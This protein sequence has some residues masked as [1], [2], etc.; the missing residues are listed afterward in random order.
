MGTRAER[1][2]AGKRVDNLAMGQGMGCAALGGI[3]TFSS[4]LDGVDR[5]KI[6]QNANDY[7]IQYM[8]PK[9]KLNEGDE[10]AIYARKYQQKSL[11]PNCNEE[12]REHRAIQAPRTNLSKPR[13]MNMSKLRLLKNKNKKS[14]PSKQNNA[15]D[16]DGFHVTNYYQQPIQQNNQEYV[17]EFVYETQQKVID[18]ETELQSNSLSAAKKY[19]LNKQLKL[20]K[21][22]IIRYQRKKAQDKRRFESGL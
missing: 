8:K 5:M 20:E 19:A 11:M 17:D 12:K 10:M 4:L 21:S 1:E 6:E 7:G 14:K 2:A 16:N 18:I 9:S 22:K 13:A 15:M 3:T